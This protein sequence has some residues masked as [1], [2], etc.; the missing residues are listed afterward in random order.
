MW[1]KLLLTDNL[2]ISYVS[3]GIPT[4]FLS[5]ITE[6][7]SNYSLVEDGIVRFEDIMD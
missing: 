7:R 6:V 4:S 2:S 1:Q 5:E 3:F